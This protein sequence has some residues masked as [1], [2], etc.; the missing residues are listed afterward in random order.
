MF[1]DLLLANEQYAATFSL[2]GLPPRAAKGLG[3]V[4]CIDSRI[5]PLELLGLQPGDAKIV[6]NAGGR[7]TEDALR[8]LIL[9]VALLGVNRVVVMHHTRCALA[10]KRDEDL[11]ADVAKSPTGLRVTIPLLAMPDP[12]VA[13]REDVFAVRSSDIGGVVDVEGWRYNVDT[14]VV[15]VVVPSDEGATS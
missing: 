14:G 10:G 2:Q 8:S 1:E 7:V 11:R 6:R 4:T 3:L 15:S 9:A 13:L 5:S 12:D